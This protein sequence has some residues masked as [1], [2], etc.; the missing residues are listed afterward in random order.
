MGLFSNITGKGVLAVGL[1]GAFASAFAMGLGAS[2]YS[3]LGLT[4]CAAALSFFS[5]AQSVARKVLRKFAQVPAFPVFVLIGI[6]AVI[7]ARHGG[8]ASVVEL[9]FLLTA[10]DGNFFDK[11]Y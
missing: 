11:L 1:A 4:G 7:A 3:I 5:A 10:M 8:N 6:A 2:C 9:A